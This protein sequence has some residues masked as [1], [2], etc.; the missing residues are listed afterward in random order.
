MK[1]RST[2]LTHGVVLTLTV[3]LIQGLC[4][5]QNR[6]QPNDTGVFTS[7]CDIVKNGAAFDGKHIKTRAFVVGGV[8][9]GIVLVEDNCR[10]GL[11]LDASESVRE[12]D[13]YLAF[14]RTILAE[15][16]GFTRDSVSRLSATFY[17][18]LTYHPNDHQKWVLNVERIVDIDIKHKIAK[19]NS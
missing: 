1:K 18:L 15:K 17:G 13:D 2:I 6:S 9:H 8:P 12:H 10:G 11:T 19:G 7:V 16:G 4:A 14:M 3:G 5:S